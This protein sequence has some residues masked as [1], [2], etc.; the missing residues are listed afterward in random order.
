MCDK[1]NDVK[2][3]VGCFSEQITKI[4]EQLIKFN[5]KDVMLLIKKQ[6]IKR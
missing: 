3:T 5:N 4:Q 6:I 1:I 2:D